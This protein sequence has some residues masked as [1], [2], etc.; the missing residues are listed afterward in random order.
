M[1]EWQDNPTPRSLETSRANT[2]P[3]PPVLLV[4]WGLAAWFIGGRVVLD[5][6]G[7]DDMP[8]HIVGWGIGAGGLAL[9][10]WAAWELHKHKTTIRPDGTS[11]VLVTTGPYA[12][13]RNPIY[14]GDA[15]LLLFCGELTK[16][17]WFI[18]A[19][20]LF[21]LSVTVLQIIPEERHLEARF[22]DVYLDYKRRTRRWI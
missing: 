7:A 17:V 10:G 15:M 21:S 9:I 2:F 1:T 19:A 5:W 16:N 6:P 18:L 20:A 8:A 13:L 14:V 11:T 22:G 3:W 12:L 4:L